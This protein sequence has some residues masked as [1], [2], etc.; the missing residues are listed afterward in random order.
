MNDKVNNFLYKAKQWKAEM[1]LLRAIII[2]CNLDEDY[3]WMHP[4]YTFEGKN[5]V[6]IH[7]FKEYC[8]L[9]FFKGVLMKDKHNLLIQ[10]TENVQDR[11][12]LRFTN[13][14]EIEST[15]SIIIDYVKEAIEIEKSGQKIIYKKTDEFEMP[16]EFHQILQNDE[17]IHQAFYNLTAGR[18]RAYLLYFSSAKQASTRIKRIE[19]YLP[20]ILDGKGKDD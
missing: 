19:S 10:Q 4:C 14:N 2:S 11:R 1:E 17:S 3:K 13:I 20:K 12:Q 5:I 6:L 15:K 7:E 18:Q 9:L 16:I 8:A